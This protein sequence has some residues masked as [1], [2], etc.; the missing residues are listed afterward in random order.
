MYFKSIGHAITTIT[1]AKCVV[2]VI[3]QTRETVDELKRRSLVKSFKN[4]ELSIASLQSLK[5]EM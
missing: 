4:T 1:I 5:S 3:Y 2:Q